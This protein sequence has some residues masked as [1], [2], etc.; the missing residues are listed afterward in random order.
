MVLDRGLDAG[1]GV[2]H[3]TAGHRPGNLAHEHQLPFRRTDDDG[4]A[5]VLGAR[6]G[7]VG[8]TAAPVVVLGIYHLAVDGEP[9]GVDVQRRHEHRELYAAAFEVLPLV[10]LLQGYHLA[11]GGRH[12]GVNRVA[13]EMAAGGA[14]EV[15]NQKEEHNR[16][17]ADGSGNPPKG[18]RQP[19]PQGDVDEQ[20]PG[21]KDCQHMG[22]FAVYL[23]SHFSSL[24]SVSEVSGYQERGGSAG[25]SPHILKP[26]RG[27]TAAD[28]ASKTQR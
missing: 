7:E 27:K 18:L 1:V 15:H 10:G 25:L 17:Q 22:A 3:D 11:V 21:G 4:R 13:G 26:E 24:Y 12:H 20:Q 9:V 2:G 23:Y 28:F 16:H 6:F 19:R 14:V 5:L 8:G